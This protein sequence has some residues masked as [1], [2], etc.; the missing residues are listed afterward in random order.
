MKSSNIN[1][2]EAPESDYLY[3]SQSQIPQSGNGLFTAVNLYKDETV[4]IFKGE[5]LSDIQVKERADAG[6]DQ[7]FINLLDGRI[8]D[9]MNVKCFAKYANDADGASNSQFKNNCRIVLDEEGDVCIQAIK[10]IKA[11]HELLC[12]YGKRYWKKHGC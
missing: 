4:S 2:I 10:N 12:S 3:V 6:N 9:S 7:Y 5:I 1:S 11:N 8:L